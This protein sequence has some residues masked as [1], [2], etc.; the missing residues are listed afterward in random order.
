MI[1]LQILPSMIRFHKCDFIMNFFL[2]ANVTAPFNNMWTL[3]WFKA[4]PTNAFFTA[5]HLIVGT[6]K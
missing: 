6:K 5:E 1:S 4:Q 2:S 3:N